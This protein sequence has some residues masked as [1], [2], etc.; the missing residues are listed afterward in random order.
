MA[1]WM[2]NKGYRL[3]L[4]ILIIAT[5]F[6]LCYHLGENVGEFIYHITH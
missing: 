4:K 6:S 2:K 5:A 1:A 3:L